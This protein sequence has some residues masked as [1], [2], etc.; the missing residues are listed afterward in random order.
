MG[1][2]ISVF[3]IALGQP[4]ADTLRSLDPKEVDSALAIHADG[5]I[6]VC[7]IFLRRRV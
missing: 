4:A 6:P 1:I 2:G 5:S 7:N 3:P